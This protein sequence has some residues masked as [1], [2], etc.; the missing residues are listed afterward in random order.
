MDI[1]KKLAVSDDPNA[2]VGW[3]G[4][5]IGF[6][7]MAFAFV[8]A[9]T[10][11]DVNLSEMLLPMGAL[12]TFWIAWI[13]IHIIIAWIHRINEKRAIKR[14]FNEGIW[15]NWQFS[16]PE[17]QKLVDAECKLISPYEKGPKAFMGAIYSSIFGIIFAGIMLAVTEFVI[18]DVQVKPAMRIGS[19]AVF[20]LFLGVGLLQPIL[21]RYK[22]KRYR[23]KAQLVL[24]PRVW[25]AAQGIYH[26]TLGHISLK[27][28][29][30]VTDQTRSRKAITFTLAITTVFG[31]SDNSSASTDLLPFSFPVPAGCEERAAR[32]VRRYRENLRQ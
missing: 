15:E 2:S 30:K 32:L 27:E 22:A 28:L 7:I 16:A 23:I 24:E 17:W 3:T 31:G 8:L 4:F 20:L 19:A 21:A 11:Y 25:Y 29:V 12:S 14:M 9:L 18:K 5:V 10:T 1:P 26:E 13:G 6:G